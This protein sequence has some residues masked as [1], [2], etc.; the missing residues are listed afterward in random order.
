MAFDADYTLKKIDT[1]LGCYKED[2]DEQRSTA[3]DINNYLREVVS[4]L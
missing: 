4:Y 3:E 1:D 2:L